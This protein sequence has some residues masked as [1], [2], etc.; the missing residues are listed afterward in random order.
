MKFFFILCCAFLLQSTCSTAQVADTPVIQ[1]SL[2]DT[3]IKITQFKNI[4]HHLLDSNIFL[5]SKGQPQAFAIGF[6]T[7]NNN[8]PFFYLLATLLFFLGL[9]KT[10]FSKY[11]STLIRVFFNT[12]LRQNQLTDQ[13]EQAKLPSLF[14]NAFFVFSGG[15]YIYF[16]HQYFSKK[17][18]E[19]NWNFLANCTAALAFIYLVKYISILFTG[20]VTSIKDDAKMYIFIVFLFNKFIGIALIPFTLLMAFSTKKIA[21]Y[22]IFLSFILL[23]LLF[24]TRFFRAYG[25][26]QAKLKFNAFHFLIYILALEILPIAL[27]Y[28][29]VMIFLGKI[30]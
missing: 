28:K 5:Q 29:T 9:L 6:K 19:L 13:L 4:Y 8:E 16:L 15:L 27:I 21:G 24:I 20:W 22:A 18:N 10:V 23:S 11:F 14:F 3:A 17:T 12:S 1:N 30:L 7:P 2:T 25:L 26:L